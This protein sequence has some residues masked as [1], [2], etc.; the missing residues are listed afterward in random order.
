MAEF[1]K[2]PFCNK[3]VDIS[4]P[5]L[6]FNRLLGRWVFDHWCEDAYP[7]TGVGITVYGKTLAELID[8]WNGVQHEQEHPSD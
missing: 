8:K 6:H 5:K 3:E 2:C 4:R 7:D 1:R